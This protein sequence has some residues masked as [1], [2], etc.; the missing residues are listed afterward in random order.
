VFVRTSSGAEGYIQAKYV[1][2][3]PSFEG[4][5]PPSNS[6]ASSS[7][8]S[9]PVST[10]ASGHFGEWRAVDERPEPGRYSAAGER[11][12]DINKCVYFIPPF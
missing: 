7:Q 4:S 11:L 6:S 5:H 1:V 3:A 10:T 9:E 2:R 8:I 12:G